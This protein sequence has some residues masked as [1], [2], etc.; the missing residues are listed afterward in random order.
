MARDFALVLGVVMSLHHPA[1]HRQPDRRPA[2]LP[3]GPE[4]PHASEAAPHPRVPGGAARGRA[5]GRLGG[6]VRLRRAASRVSLRA[7][8]AR[9]LHRCRR[10][11]PPASVRL[12]H[13]AGS[14][15]A[16]T[17]AKTAGAFIRWIS[18]TGGRLFGVAP[19]GVLFLWGS[20]GFGRDVFSRVLYG[21]RISLLTGLVAAF[22][23]LSLGS[24]V[25]HARGLSW[26]LGGRPADARRGTLPGASVAL[27]VA[28]RARLPAAAHFHRRRRSSCWWRS[29]ARWAGCGR[30]A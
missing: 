5:A 7:A 3:R 21:G 1:D 13:R 17:I 26:R 20:D 22:L 24:A 16:E 12:R 15:W 11:L 4:D 19:P 18:F 2:A 14:G 8:H 28:R 25:G 29:S 27:S 10:P 6:P 30:R 9:P 23:S